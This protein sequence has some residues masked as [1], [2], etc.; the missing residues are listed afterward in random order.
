MTDRSDDL[1]ALLSNVETV[2]D[3][4]RGDLLHGLVLSV[5]ADGLIVDLGLKRD[6]IVPCADLE[7][8][9][10]NEPGPIVGDEVAVMVIDPL[11][12]DGNL[13]V[14]ISQ[15]RES[16]DWLNAH[17][18]MNQDAILELEPSGYNK[19]GLI[20]PFGRL[21]GFVPASHL[22]DL[23]RG[24]DETKR[25]EYF[26]RMI[27][28]E[29]P[30]KVIEV[31]PRRRRLVLS[32]RKA[33][34]QWRQVRKAQMI[35]QIKV[36]EI[37]KGVVTSLREFGAFVDIGG[38]DGLIHISELSWNR[39]DDPSDVLKIGQEIDIQVIRLDQQNNRIGLSLKRLQP[40][41]WE[42]AVGKIE[43]GQELR[44]VVSHVAA[45]GIY[46]LL[47]EGPEGL[48]RSTEGTIALTPGTKVSVRVV[49]FDPERERLDLE[50]LEHGLEKLLQ[51]GE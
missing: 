10:V 49:A 5:D 21:R 4:Q 33:V 50:L 40:N 51:P 45:S 16:E 31:D 14:S 24:L 48:L 28:Q 15:A 30:F 18:L 41:P 13:V 2:A 20:V 39:V 12:R 26:E 43:E 19:G 34:R 22:S 35:E 1:S 17:R 29:L 42:A 23:P 32:E 38:A 25:A 8:L 37:R 47:E 3:P 9:P 27:G 36:G 46:I 6:G 11:D 7:K 44:G